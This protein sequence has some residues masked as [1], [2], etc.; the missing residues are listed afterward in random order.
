MSLYNDLLTNI[1]NNLL[2]RNPCVCVATAFIIGIVLNSFLPTNASQGACVVALVVGTIMCIA[3][4]YVLK[5]CRLAFSFLWFCL[6][7][8]VNASLHTQHYA[9]VPDGEMVCA[10]IM[11]NLEEKSKTYKAT[12]EVFGEKPSKAIVY[13]KKDSLSKTLSYG[14]VVTIRAK[15]REIENQENATFDYK[16]FLAYQYIYS[17]AYVGADRWQRVGYDAD[18]F[19]YCMNVRAKALEILHE[20]GLFDHNLQLIA[21]LVFGDKSLL[22]EETRGNFSTAGVM[23]VLAVSGLHVGVVSGILF[24][25]FS[26]I[27]KR[28]YLWIKIVCCVCCIWIYACITGMSPSVERAAIMCSM[29]SVSLLLRRNLSTYNSLAS[30]AFLSLV[31]S[32][33]DVFS[34]SFQLSYMAVLSIVYFGHYIQEWIEPEMPIFEYLWGIVAVSLSVQIGTLPLT[35]YYFG[36]IPL[37]NLLGNIIVIP[38]A[39]VILVGVLAFLSVCWFVPLAKIIVYA[40]N[41]VTGYLQNCIADITTFPHANLMVHISL[42]QMCMIYGMV[43]MLMFAIEYR[44]LLQIQKNILRL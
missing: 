37:Y 13:F 22:D 25:L 39:F 30:A 34:V 18:I 42:P 6:A 32:P 8:Y 35:I 21:A 40:L 33:N 4:A 9:R 36:T 16:A 38:L 15:F 20:S 27:R 26:F 44:Q 31:L 41:F 43:A 7:G 14:D 10:K 24:F 3:L 5:R 19:S 12:I 29:V 17:Q 11:S 1:R 23:H 2:A 28:K